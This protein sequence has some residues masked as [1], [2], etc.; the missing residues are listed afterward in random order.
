MRVLNLV[1]LVL[2]ASLA[3]VYAQVTAAISGHVEDGSGSGV[4][5]AIVTVKS[6]ETGG[7]RSV[8]TDAA[9]NFRVLSLPGPW[10]EKIPPSHEARRT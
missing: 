3:P 10:R 4:S 1:A 2:V 6:V 8:M 5:D 9:G 7:V